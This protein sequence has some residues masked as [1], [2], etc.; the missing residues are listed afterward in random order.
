MPQ[1]Q[2]SFGNSLNSGVIFDASTSAF[3]TISNTMT[4]NRSEHE[5]VLLSNG[6]VLITGGVGGIPTSESAGSS[7]IYRP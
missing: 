6:R 4:Q 5:A 7:E 3:S 1:F 2:E